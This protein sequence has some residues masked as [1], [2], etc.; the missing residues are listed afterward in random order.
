MRRFRFRQRRRT[1]FRRARTIVRAVSG[2]TLAKRIVLDNLTVPDVTTTDFD[3]PLDVDLLQCIEA[4]D[5]EQISDGT[6]VA[7]AP[8][9]S[10]ITSFKFTG[11]MWAGAATTVRWL[12][13]KDQDGDEQLTALA[14]A[15]FHGSND[16]PVFREARK[17]TIAKGTFRLPADRLQSNFRVFVSRKALARISPLREN[18]KLRLMVAKDAAGTTASLNGFGTIYI[19]ANA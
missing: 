1:N 2:I 11:F 16:T 5:E 4:Q 7:D 8:L 17:N 15:S 18:D 13:I 10:R 6:V 9:Y 12:L 3:N 14:N 19:K